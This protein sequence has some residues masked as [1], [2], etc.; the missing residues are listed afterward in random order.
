[1]PGPFL[2]TAPPAFL[3]PP[4][5]QRSN[6]V[7]VL[8]DAGWTW[9]WAEGPPGLVWC[10]DDGSDPLWSTSPS[11]TNWSHHEVLLAGRLCR[12]TRRYSLFSSL[13][14]RLALV[15]SHRKVVLPKAGVL[16]TCSSDSTHSRGYDNLFDST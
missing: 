12:K 5:T 15:S 16:T 10:P 8:G 13:C 4:L 9:V 6:S 14:R 3:P 2:V 11:E 1:M 7:G